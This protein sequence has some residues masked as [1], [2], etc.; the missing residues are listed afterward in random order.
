MKSLILASGSP[1][2]AEILT[3]GG[4]TFQKRT[5]E[6]DE[7]L[8]QGIL[9]AQAV[10]LLATRKGKAVPRA[11][12]EVLLSADTVVAIDDRILGKPADADEAFSMLRLLSG[13]THSVFTG[14]YIA[15]NDKDYCFSVETKV[16]FLPLTDAEIRRYIETGEPMDKA[17]A[18][19]IQG[20]GALLVESI[21]GDYLNVVGLPL[22]KTAQILKEVL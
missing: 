16:Q 18:Y 2:R 13:R 15:T 10:E 7:S 5:A 11:E 3:Q 19:G 17:G 12:N 14:V 6:T 4:F 20:K 8:P 1:R 9:P 21:C 22:S